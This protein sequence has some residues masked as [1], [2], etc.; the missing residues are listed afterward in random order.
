[1]NQINFSFVLSHGDENNESNNCLAEGIQKVGLVTVNA[2]Q[3]Y[4]KL[5]GPLE[6]KMKLVLHLIVNWLSLPNLMMML[7]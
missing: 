1:M 3:Q 7:K 2:R 6:S 4:H 5:Q